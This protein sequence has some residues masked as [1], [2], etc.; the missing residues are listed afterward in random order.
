MRIYLPYDIIEITGSLRLSV[1]DS[2]RVFLL[3]QQSITGLGKWN[4]RMNLILLHPFFSQKE[5][6]GYIFYRS[7]KKYKIL[8]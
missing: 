4:T 1:S 7:N 2:N 5:Y 3:Q 8:F 6:L